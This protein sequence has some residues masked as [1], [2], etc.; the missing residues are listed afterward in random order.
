M[1]IQKI[2]I[3]FGLLISGLQIVCNFENSGYTVRTGAGQRP[4]RS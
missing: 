3:P 1:S 4:A 2:L